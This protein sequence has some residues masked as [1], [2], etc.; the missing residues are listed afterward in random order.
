M[1]NYLPF[2]MARSLF[3]TLLIEI[4][5]AL[6]LGAR[7]K[8]EVANVALVNIMTN[9]VAVSVSF[10]VNIMLGTKAKTVSL[11]IIEPLAVFIEGL[12]YKKTLTCK[13]INP[14]LFSLLLNAASYGIGLIL[15]KIL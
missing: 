10:A 13:K 14:Y 7:N 12:V 1:I 15:N 5:F 3:F 9:P 6:I 8:K 11:L 4:V 2:Y